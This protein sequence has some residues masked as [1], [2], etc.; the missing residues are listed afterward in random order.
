[1]IVSV[2]VVF[3]FVGFSPD[4]GL[5]GT[6]GAAA[7]VNGDAISLRDYKELLDRLDNDNQ[8]GGN[9][10][11]A[12][13]RVQENA[14]NILVSRSLIAQEADKLNIYVSDKEVA[15]ALLDIEPFYEDGVF[16]RLRYKTYLRQARLSE[17]DFENKIRQ[18]L[19]IQK[20]SN[21]LGFAAK[22]LTIVDD[23]DS[24]ID[25]AQVNLGYVTLNPDQL[26]GGQT[27]AS[28]DFIAKNEDKIKSY[29]EAH[30]SEFATPEQVKAKHILVKAAD[31]KKESMDAALKKVNEL[32]PTLTVANFAE[33]AKKTSDDPGSKANGG[34]LGLF[35]RGKMVPEFEKAAFS[36]EPGKISEPVQT[37][38]GYHVLL[39]E[40]KVPAT[41]KTL[42]DVK[43][44]I[45]SKLQ[46]NEK[47]DGI[48]AEVKKLLQAKDYAKLEVYLTS[49]NLKWSST[50]FFSITKDNVPGVGQ[51]QEFL[52][53]GL[54]LGPNKQYADALVYQGD[55]AY[56]LKF[57]GA[58]ID[59]AT[60]ANN[61]MDFFKQL[62]KQ[63]K[64]NILVQNWT[65]SL[66]KTAKVK[67]NGDLIQ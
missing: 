47:F 11:E 54:A 13:N 20:M 4:Q 35:A 30:K 36:L 40:K 31:N 21:L 62:M 46:A 15:Q 34:E 1:M 3:V 57:T 2:C 6:G 28:A 29:Y 39:V 59:E 65:E 45:A 56:L 63:Q 49:K 61:Q 19:I 8:A 33:V 48:Q 50:G 37:Q 44:V 24:K 42:D 60:G 23:F 64:M 5:L 10:K 51:S 32:L 53:V 52:D 43:S 25:K 58:R 67:V 27:T 7:E 17:S 55:N 14:I 16:S 41:E 22:D 9:D 12:R 18:D 66:R 26:G 38:Y